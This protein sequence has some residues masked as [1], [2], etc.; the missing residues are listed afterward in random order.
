MEQLKQE[1]ENFFHKM[2]CPSSVS[3]QADAD[4]VLRISVQTD[5]A[6]FLIGS[7]GETI[8]C[9]DSLLKR[10]IQKKIP[11]APQFFID[12]NDYRQKRFELLKE[13]AKNFAKQ[14]RLYRKE[15]TLD[16]M[17]ALERRVIHTTLSE[18]PDI[19][20]ESVGSGLERR[21]VIKPFQ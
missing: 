9:L 21:I 1:V 16:P 6:R 14:V 11:D 13:D 19:V 2:T 18:Y 15:V 8:A 5:N 10:L 20:T 12:I 4:G 3:L 17:P 7:G